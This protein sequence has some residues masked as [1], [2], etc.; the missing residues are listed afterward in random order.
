MRYW[1][2]G[3]PA[4]YVISP[5]QQ[6]QL[7][8][9]QVGYQTI[10]VPGVRLW[11]YDHQTGERTTDLLDAT[12]N[13]VGHIVTAEYGA[14]PRFRGPDEVRRLLIGP[15]PTGPAE[16]EPGGDD[17]PGENQGRWT[18]TTVDWPVIT[19]QLDTRIGAMEDGGGGGEDPDP[20][21]SAH[22]LV[23]THPGQVAESRTSPHPVWNLDG[24]SQRVSTVRAQATITSGE[25]TCTVMTIDPDTGT[26]TPIAALLLNEST[27]HAIVTPDAPVS[28]GTGLT[29]RVELGT[30]DDEAADVTV[31]V[32]VR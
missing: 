10:L 15:E 3:G 28:G 31:Q 8:G 9:E 1:F 11:C 32:M 17:D 2:G 23:W 13:Q 14:V 20:V 29:V 19:D 21:G 30:A 26:H 18:I 16:P 27:G 7:P 12:G 24:R 25:L 22:P 6:A 5:G 4:D